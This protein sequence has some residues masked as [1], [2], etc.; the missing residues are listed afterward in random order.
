MALWTVWV[1]GQA[2]ELSES[3]EEAL[4]GRLGSWADGSGLIDRLDAGDAAGYEPSPDE[5]TALIN[6]ANDVARSSAPAA[7][8]SEVRKLRAFLI[9]DQP[10]G[11]RSAETR[12]P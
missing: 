9:E 7:V 12:L 2:F 10:V 11:E 6:A 1:R 4:R 5:R 3:A 8:K